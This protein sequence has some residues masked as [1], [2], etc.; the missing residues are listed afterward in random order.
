M[1]DK[2]KK[3]IDKLENPSDKL[4]TAHFY[5]QISK[6]EFYTET[7]K[8]FHFSRFSVKPVRT[9]FG[10]VS[11]SESWLSPTVGESS[12]WHNVCS[13]E[14][15]TGNVVVRLVVFALLD[16]LT[17]VIDRHTYDRC[18]GKCSVPK[19]RLKEY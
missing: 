13:L 8:F 16:N 12:L 14:R 9:I 19:T 17:G 7:D 11:I 10:S 18:K 1:I 4:E 6:I 2:P 3:S 15:H 5:P